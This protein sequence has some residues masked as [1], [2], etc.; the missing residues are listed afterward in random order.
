M[1]L[2]NRSSLSRLFDSW[3]AGSAPTGGETATLHFC[4]EGRRAAFVITDHGDRTRARASEAVY[5]GHSDLSHP[6]HG[7]R[8]LL[9]AGVRI[10]QGTFWSGLPGF[11]YLDNP[12]FYALMVE[13]AAEGSEVCPHNTSENLLPLGRTRADLARYAKAFGLTT[14]IDH[15][16]LPT[17]L[18]KQGCDPASGHHILDAFKELGG[19]AAWSFDD[20]ITNPPAG[21][22][23]MLDPPGIGDFGS[24]VLAEASLGL[25]GQPHNLRARATALL[26]HTVGSAAIY[27]LL[28]AAKQPA[29]APSR[30]LAARMSI[31]EAVGHAR[32][33]RARR[34]RFPWRWDERLGLLW[35]DAVRVNLMSR[36]YRAEA[37]DSLVTANE[38]H[39]GHTYLGFTDDKHGD[40]AVRP[41][42]EHWAL[43]EDVHEFLEHLATLIRAGSV[44]NPTIRE[45]SAWY[46]VLGEI[47]VVQDQPAR[48][49]VTVTNRSAEPI[50]G[51]TL[52]SRRKLASTSTTLRRHLRVGDEHWYVLDLPAESSVCLGRPTAASP[53]PEVA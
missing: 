8:G 22:L 52:R 12:A 40:I 39:I 42:G 18:T 49:A 2:G 50:N 16:H 53:N 38:M 32:S 30:S 37:L 51:V 41:E 33:M 1:T 43:R 21:I 29:R 26:N 25:R 13:A 23:A 31:E 9:A 17:N 20:A 19:R 3:R 28:V 35:F 34:G 7:R 15:G 10:T 46:L 4:P 5:K 44:W 47:D 24:A 27:N 45:M 11:D 14:F 48:H 6:W 36:V